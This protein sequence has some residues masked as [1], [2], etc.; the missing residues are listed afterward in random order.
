MYSWKSLKSLLW[1]D[2]ANVCI[3][4]N[5][6]CLGTCV[7]SGITRLPRPWWCVLRARTL[8]SYSTISVFRFVRTRRKRDRICT[9]KPG[10]IRDSSSRMIKESNFHLVRTYTILNIN[11]NFLN[12]M[13]R[14]KMQVDWQRQWRWRL[15]RRE[16][17]KAPVTRRRSV[18][19]SLCWLP[20]SSMEMRTCHVVW[21]QSGPGQYAQRLYL[22]HQVPP[23]YLNLHTCWYLFIFSAKI[24]N[25]CLGLGL[26]SFPSFFRFAQNVK[27]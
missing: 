1:E 15:W 7:T 20:A 8:Y 18:T 21:L 22:P 4:S 26:S 2:E 10:A 9:S 5:F 23:R 16:R 24:K 19:A 12:L 6:F 17:S 3:V 13:R 11:Q 27:F 14:G 25:E